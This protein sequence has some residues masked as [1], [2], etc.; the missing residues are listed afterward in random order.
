MA[1]YRRARENYYV[2]GKPPV[3]LEIGSEGFSF[4]KPPL[5]SLAARRRAKPI[6]EDM[7]RSNTEV[8]PGYLRIGHQGCLPA[9]LTLAWRRAVQ[10]PW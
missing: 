5:G 4:L 2:S 9:S 7:L 6:I 10:P 1:N 3:G 8:L